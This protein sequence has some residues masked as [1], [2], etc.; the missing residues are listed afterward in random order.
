MTTLLRRSPEALGLL[1]GCLAGGTIGHLLLTM[2]A[3]P[4]R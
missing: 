2:G 3:Y 1:F 4:W